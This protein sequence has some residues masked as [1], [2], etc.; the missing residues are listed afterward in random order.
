MAAEAKPLAASPPL[1][2]Q[3]RTASL[4]PQQR[5]LNWMVTNERGESEQGESE[6]GA[7][8]SPEVVA[9]AA[10][11]T[12]DRMRR[13]AEEL[14]STLLCPITKLLMTDPV[15]TMDGQVTLT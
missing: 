4:T 3:Q 6:Q 14:A 13:T 15:F 1:T 8:A 2:P 11:Q 10:A 9:V 7:L 12:A 5:A